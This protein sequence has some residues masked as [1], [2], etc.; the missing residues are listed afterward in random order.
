MSELERIEEVLDQPS[1]AAMI[2]ALETRLPIGVRPRQLSVRTLLIGML[3]CLS[4]GLRN[5]Y[6]SALH[7]AL[8]ELD[9]DDRER[10]GVL[11]CW[12]VGPHELTYRQVEYTA[13][14][15][16][17]AL[18]KQRPDGAPSKSLQELCDTLVESSLPERYKK[19]SS[20]YA[21]DWTDMESFSRPPSEKGGPCADPEASWGHRRGDGPGQK[22]ELFFGRYLSFM[23]MV[24]DEGGEAV[25]ELIR[26]MSLTSCHL[27]PVAAFVPVVT[28]SAASGVVIFDVLADSGYAHRVPEHFAL[29]LRAIGASLVIDLHP[30]DR[31]PRGTF[32]GAT[33]HNGNL[34]CPGTPKALLQLGPLARGASPGEVA[35]HDERTAELARYKLGR[36]TSDDVD[37]YHRVCCPAVMGKCRCPQRPPSMALSNTRPEVLEAPAEHPLACCVRQSVT[38]PPSVNAKTA[39]KHDYPSAAHRRSYARRS[40]AERSN[41]RVKD[42]AGINID[43]RG[44]CKLMGVAPLSIFLACACVVVNFGLID[45]FETHKAEQAART[46]L[47]PPPRRRRR[48]TTL[49]A[50]VA[51]APGDAPP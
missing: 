27:D 30:S 4:N 42:P 46:A 24:A 37:G 8:V 14:L 21:I 19:A 29:P 45:C 51:P 28:D 10:L 12:R 22:D 44:W 5:A 3:L 26:R 49:A 11:V 41:S 31:G 33:C 36:L 2:A 20:S 39:Q 32:S 40:G 18:K 9:D 38:V 35:A 47:G 23:T 50:L 6:L 17:T 13:G 25:P 7:G 1:C 43:V 16:D 15:I 48:R 34:Y